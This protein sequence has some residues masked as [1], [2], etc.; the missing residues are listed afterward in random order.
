MTI[1]VDP[2]A[3]GASLLPW[4]TLFALAGV[5]V[6]VALFVRRGPALGVSRRAAYRLALWA[7]LWGLAGARAGHVV[8][9]AGFFADA[10][11]EVIYLWN[12]GLSLWGALIGGVA[13][14]AWHSRRWAA[15]LGRL[16][17]LAVAPAFVG[18]ALGRAGDLL[19]GARPATPT[20]LPWGTEYAHIDAEA[21][22]ASG[23]AVHPVAA[24]ELLVD[25]AVLGLILHFRGRSLP[26]GVRSALAISTYAAFRF[27]IAFA[28]TDPVWGGLQQAQW[29]GLAVV[30]TAVWWLR[31]KGVRLRYFASR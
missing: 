16:L 27:V 17:D 24:Y 12:G 5:A 23:A 18:M 31:R 11:F 2:N 10:P 25:A 29:L 30:V 26:G 22:V 13:G 4:T 15:S 1:D 6:G 20:S 3:L 21:H 14:L 9:H 19:A 7:V 8:D 28:R